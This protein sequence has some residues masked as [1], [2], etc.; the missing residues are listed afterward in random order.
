MSY[1]QRMSHKDN[2]PSKT[3]FNII[4]I[5]VP[6][7]FSIISAHCI[8]RKEIHSAFKMLLRKENTMIT[9]K[10][11]RTKHRQGTTSA[12]SQYKIR[13][14]EWWARLNIPGHLA[15]LKGENSRE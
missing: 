11:L 5:I 2:K 1:E 8:N 10:D 4:I 7:A 14:A 12:V 6:I 9:Q 13:R 3:L 15:T